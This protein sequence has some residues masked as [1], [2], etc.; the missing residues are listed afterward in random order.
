MYEVYVC[1]CDC[2]GY[3]VRGRGGL[4][5]SLGE[6]G[7]GGGVKGPGR[8]L[9]GGSVAASARLNRFWGGKGDG[10]SARFGRGGFSLFG[11]GRRELGAGF[12]GFVVCV[13]W[14]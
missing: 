5:Y 9:A 2:H 14:D 4:P 12:N 1:V 6:G 3:M 7:G 11:G 13:V 8:W 10:R